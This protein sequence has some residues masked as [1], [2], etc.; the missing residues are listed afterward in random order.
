MRKECIPQSGEHKEED[1]NEEKQ[2]N[3]LIQEIDDEKPPK[4]SN[5]SGKY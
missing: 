1:A 5:L 2:N 4:P 3:N